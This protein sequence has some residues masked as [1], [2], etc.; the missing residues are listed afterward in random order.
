M[1][2][3][4][5]NS[6]IIGGGYLATSPQPG[7]G[8]TNV[9]CDGRL[10]RQAV[11]ETFSTIRGGNGTNHSETE[12]ALA[13]YLHASTTSNRFQTLRRVGMTFDTRDIPA[14][15]TI[16]SARLLLYGYD[17]LAGL[18][19]TSL[20]VCAFTPANPADFVNA[21][22]NLT[23]WPA[24]SYGSISY[25]SWS[26]SGYNTITLSNTAV[27]RG[28]ITALGLR[29]DWDFSN[30]TTGLTWASNAIT[31]FYARSADYGLDYAPRLEVEYQ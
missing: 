27:N 3:Y 24:T 12:T 18:G 26:T 29:L 5:V 28:G 11:D 8:G 25:S 2:Q 20:I 7:A 21:D 4:L 16:L 23:N 1:S 17:K 22:F 31:G 9:T 30:T 15:A 19:Q 6:Y 13:P 14:N 10:A